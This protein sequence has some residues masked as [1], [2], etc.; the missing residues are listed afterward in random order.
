MSHL[1]LPGERSYQLDIMI[2]EEDYLWPTWLYVPTLTR[3]VDEVVATIRI[4][5]VAADASWSGF[6]EGCGGPPLI[7][8]AFWNLLQCFLKGGPLARDTENDIGV[9]V[10]SLFIDVRTPDVPVEMIAPMR[11]VVEGEEYHECLHGR[12]R[13][14]MDFRQKSG[15]PYLMNPKKLVA[16]LVQQM[17]RLLD[18]SYHTAS[19]G[20]ILYER[21][22]SIKFTLDGELWTEFDLAERLANVQFRDS[23]GKLPRQERPAVF[24]AW[25][26]ITD[27]EVQALVRTMHQRCLDVIEARGLYTKW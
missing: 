4:C 10:K 25:N 14:L 20:G 13:G 8:W 16:F 9:S 22:G 24:E 27:A 17:D 26:S 21:I 11:T 3:R 1:G 6:S 2:V 23:F 19:Y 18:M 5:G 15:I 12:Y 7:T